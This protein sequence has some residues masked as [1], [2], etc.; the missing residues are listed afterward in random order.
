MKKQIK[1]LRKLSMEEMENVK[2]GWDLLGIFIMACQYT[3]HVAIN[4]EGQARID[5]INAWGNMAY[6]CASFGIY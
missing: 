4:G 3:L 5:A 6:T 1:G 2:G